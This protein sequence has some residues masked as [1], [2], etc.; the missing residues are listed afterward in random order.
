[1]I[2]EWSTDRASFVPPWAGGARR[3][4]GHRSDPALHDHPAA[5]AEHAADGGSARPP[6]R[7]GEP[8]GPGGGAGRRGGRAGQPGG[9]AGR[10]P[11]ARP[12]RVQADQRHARV[13]TR[14]TWCSRRSGGACT[15]TRSSTTPPR[16][17]VVTSS[18][19]SC[20]SCA[21][22]MTSR[23]SRTG[24]ARRWSAR[25]T[26]TA[27]PGSSGPASVR[28]SIGEHGR[29]SAELLRAA[30]AAMYHAKRGREGVRVYDAGTDAGVARPR[31]GRRAAR[32]H[33]GGADRARLPA[34]VRARDRAD[35]RR[36]GAGSMARPGGT[37]TIPPGGVH[38]ARRGDR[39]D[40]SA[41]PPDAAQGAGRGP[42]LARRRAW[43][44]RSASTSPPGC[45]RTDPW[46]GEVSALLA[47]RGLEREALVL[48]ITETAM[49]GDLDVAL[50][51][52]GELR[53]DRRT[54]RAGR[55]R[56]RI[57]VLQ[58]PPRASA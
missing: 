54:H 38:P 57:R 1:M 21:R 17:W 43:A 18:P 16:G 27:S 10:G 11:D 44:S 49:I 4:A 22:P 24:C 25:S 26:S 47:E 3:A 9:R 34:G 48:E 14:A 32:G 29:S 39:P 37:S 51:R 56:Q 46:P 33:R 5:P 42:G 41:D 23:P 13:T 15:P 2:V 35:R 28:P 45:S 7:A 12:G 55:L 58:G 50:E 31:A 40:P 20:A 30:D 8:E 52:L 19:S 53:V 6:H 36:R